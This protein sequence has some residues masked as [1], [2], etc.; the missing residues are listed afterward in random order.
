MSFLL[1]LPVFRK[2]CKCS[3]NQQIRHSESHCEIQYD[4]HCSKNKHNQIRLI[5]LGQ[6]YNETILYFSITLFNIYRPQFFVTHFQP[7]KNSSIVCFGI[8]QHF[9]KLWAVFNV[10][11]ESSTTAICSNSSIQGRGRRDSSTS[12]NQQHISCA[13]Y[14]AASVVP[15]WW[16]NNS[17]SS[18]FFFSRIPQPF[19]RVSATLVDSSRTNRELAKY[20]K[21]D[22]PSSHT[23]HPH[24]YLLLSSS[25]FMDCS[26]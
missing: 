2:K 7:E 5:E 21:K 25:I 4:Y 12:N 26:G 10:L 3:Q 20:N 18:F 15:R 1:Y 6:S 13:K 9:L 16:S 23:Y 17:S 19:T 24:F 8:L 22:H 11:E 14:S